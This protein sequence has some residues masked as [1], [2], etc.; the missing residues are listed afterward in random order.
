MPRS[1]SEL[2]VAL[3]NASRREAHGAYTICHLNRPGQHLPRNW[4]ADL[5]GIMAELA[6]EAHHQPMQRYWNAKQD[7]FTTLDDWWFALCSDRLVAWCGVRLW[8]TPYGFVFSPENATVHPRH[9]RGRFGQLLFA[10]GWL[11]ASLKARHPLPVVAQTS[12]PIV[13]QLAA[14]LF[15]TARVIPSI[16]ALGEPT[17]D[18]RMTP[19]L[20]YMARQWYPSA[21]YDK[22]VSVVRAALPYAFYKRR[23]LS[24]QVGLN[25]FFKRNLREEPGDALIFGGRPS[26]RVTLRAARVARKLAKDLVALAASDAG[27][28]HGR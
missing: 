5:L 28:D 8:D 14:S 22:E 27:T 11:R 10:R 16:D 19:V 12:S 25:R 3:G 2:V 6:S 15:G 17:I 24:P 4:Q 9:L 7:Y 1:G 26:Y 23:P 18:R 13:Y 21:T 20:E